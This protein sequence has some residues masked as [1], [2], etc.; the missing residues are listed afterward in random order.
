M[1]KKLTE[2][3]KSSCQDKKEKYKFEVGDKVK[4]V[5]RLYDEYVAKIGVIVSR[6]NSKDK[7][8]YYV[9]FENEKQI[10]CTESVLESMGD[11]S[12]I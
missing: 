9:L 10:Y 11:N 3:F 7:I 5:G 8:G 4:Y 2:K 1:A 12:E 6:T